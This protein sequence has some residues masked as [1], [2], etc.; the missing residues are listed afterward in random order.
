[1]KTTVL[2]IALTFGLV[3]LTFAGPAQTDTSK[4][5]KPPKKKDTSK[6][7]TKKNDGTSKT[8]S[9]PANSTPTTKK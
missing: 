8:A 2:A 3:P 5:S 9:T 7:P 4:T 6:K 1:M